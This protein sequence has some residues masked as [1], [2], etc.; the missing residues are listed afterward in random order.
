MPQAQSQGRSPCCKSLLIAGTS[1]VH[2]SHE[3]CP[4]ERPNCAKC[5]Q[6]RDVCEYDLEEGVT[7]QQSLSLRS[8]AL[9]AELALVNEFV[10]K[11]RNSSDAYA[12]G[13]LAQLRMG[14]EVSQLVRDQ[15]LCLGRFVDSVNSYIRFL[16]L[17]LKK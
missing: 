8:D 13:L 7:K 10:H 2:A 15:T 9:Q 1:Y 16:V 4:G 5:L 3:Q 17:I 6:Q 11:L 12:C 14:E